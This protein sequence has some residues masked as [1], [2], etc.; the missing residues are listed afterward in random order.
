M[1]PFM[2]AVFLAGD[3][4]YQ[5]DNARCHKNRIDKD[6][7]E[8][9]TVEFQESDSD[10]D[11]TEESEDNNNES[12]KGPQLWSGMNNNQTAIL[13]NYYCSRESETFFSKKTK[14]YNGTAKPSYKLYKNAKCFIFHLLEQKTTSVLVKADVIT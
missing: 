5:P 6:R 13:L 1:Y 8:Q 12:S 2:T 3:G 11:E 10:D 4:V 7:F 14:V 9:P